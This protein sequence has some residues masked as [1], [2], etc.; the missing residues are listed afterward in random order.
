[1]KCSL[2]KVILLQSFYI[3]NL[4]YTAQ[5]PGS[6]FL[7]LMKKDYVLFVLTQ[8]EPKKAKLIKND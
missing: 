2:G 1:M 5:I 4:F 3:I 7:S 8:K 6:V